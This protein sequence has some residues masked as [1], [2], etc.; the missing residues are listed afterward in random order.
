M[1]A[2]GID[3]IKV[4][5]VEEVGV[6]LVDRAQAMGRLEAGQDLVLGPLEG[7]EESLDLGPK[8]LEARR[9]LDERGVSACNWGLPW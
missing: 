9:S 6:A 2:R 3:P 5:R 8:P 7:L 4:A 1:R